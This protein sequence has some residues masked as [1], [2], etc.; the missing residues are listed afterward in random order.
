MAS[1]GFV[2]AVQRFSHSTD[3][4]F[5]D[6]SPTERIA[7]RATFNESCGGNKRTELSSVT[8][9]GMSAYENQ[10]NRTISLRCRC[11]DRGNSLFH[12]LPTFGSDVGTIAYLAKHVCHCGCW[13]AA[14]LQKLDAHGVCVHLNCQVFITTA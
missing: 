5:H 13:D 14:V 10:K 6:P 2:R 4:A 8:A 11:G 1:I 7:R 9:G 3:S 12:P